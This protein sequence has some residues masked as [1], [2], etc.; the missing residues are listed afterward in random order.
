ML[1]YYTCADSRLAPS[2]WETSV[3]SNY[4][5]HW[6]STNLESALICGCIL[7]WLICCVF[8]YIMYG[9][10]WKY[11][12]AFYFD[13]WPLRNR[14]H[15][16]YLSFMISHSIKHVKMILDNIWFGQSD[17]VDFLIDRDPRYT[18]TLVL[19][20]WCYQYVGVDFLWNLNKEKVL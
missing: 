8:A 20:E 1:L 18:V 17:S 4:V 15:W 11:G 5:S 16:N 9:D 14:T 7:Y 19:S 3:Q 10:N 13:I 12:D 2:Q 6:L